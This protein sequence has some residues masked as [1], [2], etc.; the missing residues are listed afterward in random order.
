MSPGG[1]HCIQGHTRA[2]RKHG[3]GPE[4]IVEAIWVAA[5]TRAGGAFAHSALALDV[6][7]DNEE[8]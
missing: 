6:L 5:E 2:A 1:L 3:A 7:D 8:G 4:E